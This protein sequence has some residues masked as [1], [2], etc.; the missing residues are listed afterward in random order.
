M[1]LTKKKKKITGTVPTVKWG[2]VRNN[3][4]HL[5]SGKC[6]FVKLYSLLENDQL[7]FA[8]AC[9]LSVK[10]FET[11][12]FPIYLF[13]WTAQKHHTHRFL[14]QGKKVIFFPRFYFSSPPPCKSRKIPQIRQI[15]WVP[16]ANTPPQTLHALSILWNTVWLKERLDTEISKCY[17]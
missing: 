14:L 1:G 8:F 10:F 12:G 13:H 17:V 5:G 16:N 9:D 4:F 11:L 15:H 6:H 2:W 3:Y 7:C